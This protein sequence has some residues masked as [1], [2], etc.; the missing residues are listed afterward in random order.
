M[1]RESVNQTMCQMQLSHF[2]PS[3]DF[4]HQ[5]TELSCVFISRF[6]C[7]AALCECK[8]MLYS[9]PPSSS[10]LIKHSKRTT[11][12][13]LQCDLSVQKREEKHRGTQEC[14]L[15]ISLWSEKPLCP[16]IAWE[17]NIPRFVWLL[18]SKSASVSS[19]SSVSGKIAGILAW[20]DNY[21]PPATIIKIINVSWVRIDTPA[22]LW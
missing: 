7:C 17:A 22:P 12:Y 1:I 10:N 4:Q 8:M 20:Y 21:S 13:S 2:F 19:S 18:Q 5:Q 16:C 14:K 15:S 11:G 9:S 3:D 6:I